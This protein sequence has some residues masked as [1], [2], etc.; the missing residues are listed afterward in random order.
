MTRSLTIAL[1]ILTACETGAARGDRIRREEAAA[2]R[3]AETARMV[4]NLRQGEFNIR[5]YEDVKTGMDLAAVT[6]YLGDSGR[7]VSAGVEGG[8][9][10]S[11]HEWSGPGGVISVTFTDGAVSAKSKRDR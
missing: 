7:E 3:V 2:A 11:V 9:A 5:F 6:A 10:V 4:G 1:L 8:R